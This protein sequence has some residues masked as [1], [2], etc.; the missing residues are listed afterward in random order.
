MISSL[1]VVLLTLTQNPDPCALIKTAKEKTYGF[2]PLDLKEEKERD[3]K[4]EAMDVF[5][6]LVE[7]NGTSGTSCLRDL[8]KT[9]ERDGFFIF[10]G[11]SLLLSVDQ[12]AESLS[13]AERKLERADITQVDPGGYINIV[14]LL[15]G[16]GVDVGRLARRYM[17]LEK[18]D[19]FI[20]AHVLDVERWMGAVFLYGSMSSEQSDRYLTETLDSMSAET[21]GSAAL[22]L[23]ISMT[24]PAL[25]QLAAFKGLNDLPKTYQ[26][27]IAEMR[28]YEPYQMPKNPLLF[29]R[30]EVLKWIAIIPHTRQEFEQAV[31]REQEYEKTAKRDALQ[32]GED[33][34]P[35]LEIGGHTRF[36][37]SAMATLTEMDLPAIRE[38]RRLALRGISDESLEEYFAF[39]AI[40]QGVMNRL[41]L[42]KEYRPR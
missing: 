7:S 38:A 3:A 20:P 9:E 30:E 37:E 24:E 5:W 8:L 34:P 29:T 27:H 14:F 1:V 16:K 23:A 41:D 32:N 13:I 15:S 11:T 35:F 2:K 6:E 17:E 4:S 31:V 21:R 42:Y 25:K 36:V 26:D 12:S 18:A 28:K 19:A 33:G 22:A 10:D 39:T 40:I